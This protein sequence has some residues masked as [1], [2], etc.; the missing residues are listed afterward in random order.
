MALGQ[1]LD[2]FYRNHRVQHNVKNNSYRFRFA[3]S[4]VSW[5]YFRELRGPSQTDFRRSDGHASKDD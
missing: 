3:A 5:K 2:K 1:G 4:F